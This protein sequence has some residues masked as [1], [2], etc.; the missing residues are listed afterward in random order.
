MRSLFTLALLGVM[1]AGQSSVSSRVAWNRPFPPFRIIGN[2]YYVGASGVSSF[3]ITTPQGDILLDGGFSETAPQ[4]ERNIAKLGFKITDVKYLLNSH[5]HYDHAGGLAELKRASHA[6]FVASRGD[7]GTLSSGHQQSFGPGQ[8]DSHFP[9]VHVDRIISDGETVSLGGVTLTA[10]VTPGHIKGCTTW[11]MPVSDGGRTYQV[12]FA[13]SLSVAGNLLVNNPKYPNIVADYEASFAKMRA[14]PCDVFLGAH[15][16]FFS[17]DEKY[18]R[19]RP[20]APNP[21]IKPGELRAFVDEAQQDFEQQLA[22]QRA[23]ARQ[24]G[25]HSD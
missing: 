7:A 21:F 13:C 12:V 3:L 25:S 4:I 22:Q 23:A 17:L 19:M 14:L 18:K 9:A 20:G 2:L 5:A 1:A 15:P 8:S 24:P 11:S 10:H 16:G 6:Q